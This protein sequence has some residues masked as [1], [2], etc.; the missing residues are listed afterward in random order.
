MRDPAAGYYSV[1]NG[2]E[3]PLC[4]RALGLVLA[5]VL[6]NRMKSGSV[7]SWMIPG[8]PWMSSGGN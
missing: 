7:K 5:F 3:S 1:I 2:R 6:R 4:A 8:G